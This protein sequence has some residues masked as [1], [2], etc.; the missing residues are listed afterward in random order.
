ML[1]CTD[2]VQL[3]CVQCAL[4]LNPSETAARSYQAL[5]DGESDLC[6]EVPPRIDAN[7]FPLSVHRPM[8]QCAS[9]PDDFA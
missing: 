8:R 4:T 5:L 7:T 6:L 3:R 9:K 2:F 1:F